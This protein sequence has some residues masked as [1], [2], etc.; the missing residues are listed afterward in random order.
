MEENQTQI[1]QLKKIFLG[2]FLLSIKILLLFISSHLIKSEYNEYFKYGQINDGFITDT[3]WKSSGDSPPTNLF[4][5]KIKVG[6]KTYIYEIQN[7][8]QSLVLSTE[9]ERLIREIKKN[10]RVKIKILDD[11]KTKILEWKNLKINPKNKFSDIL[12]IWSVILALLT[13]SGFL[14]YKIYNLY[15]K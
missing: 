11:K 10:D 14:F 9:E 13:I 8:D 2:P 15:K 7:A 5:C 6:I 12:G 3:Y 4:Y 1:N